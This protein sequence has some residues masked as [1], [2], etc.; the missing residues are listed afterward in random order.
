MDRIFY[1]LSALLLTTSVGLFAQTTITDGSLVANTDYTWETGQEYLLDGLVYLEEGGTLTI[2]PGVVIKAKS[3]P[4]NGDNTSALIITKGAQIFANGTADMPIIFTAEIDDVNDPN[5]R[6]VN[7][8]RGL[9]GGVIILG[10]A[11]LATTDGTA[12]IEGIEEEP[13][14]VYGGTNDTESS[15]TMRY[16]SIRHGGKALTS[17]N[18]INGLTLG[19]VGSGTTLEYIEVIS[20]ADDGIEFFGGTVDLK[21]ASVSFCDDDSFDYDFGWQG[22]GQFWFSLTSD[23]GKCG[24]SGEHD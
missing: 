19:G 3:A 5:D 14:T 4:T 13:R 7:D 17:N 16:V 8:D 24:R 1:I 21:Y 15:G 6:D 10:N 22:S 12:S 9:W 23:I 2:E 20:N 11:T 18:E